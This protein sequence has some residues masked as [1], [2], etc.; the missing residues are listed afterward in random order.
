MSRKVDSRF[1]WMNGTVVPAEEAKVSFFAHVLHYGTGV[2]EG[3]RCYDGEKGPAVFRL[4]EHLERLRRSA[5]GYFME[6]PYSDADLTRVTCDLIKMH[7]FSECYIRPLVMMGEGRMGLK[8][9]ECEVDVG[10]TVWSWGRY[11]GEDALEMGVRTVISERLKYDPRA[12]DPTMKAVGHYLNSVKAS[13]E[14]EALGF[15][16]AILLN[17][18]GRVA[19]GPGENIF[20]VKGQTVKTNPPEESLLL[21]VTRDSLMQIAKSKGYEVVVAPIEV[22]ELLSAD[23]VFFTGTAAEVTPVASIGDQT[24][25]E[26]RRGPITEELQAAYLNAV[27]G[28]LPGF[29]SWLTPVSAQL[30]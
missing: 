25:G 21:G 8:P 15:D 4:P 30:G 27:K 2:F 29:E 10:V 28:R 24:I 13:K 18:E 3:I 9:R 6:Y 17:H 19:E 26:G 14:A 22:D 20:I 5:H 16:E 7:G 11:L 12:L 23:E 1:V